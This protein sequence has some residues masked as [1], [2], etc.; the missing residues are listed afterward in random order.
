MA[1]V[2]YFDNYTNYGRD[3]SV[4]SSVIEAFKAAGETGR[5]VQFRIYVAATTKAAALEAITAV[6]LRPKTAH[7]RIGMGNDLD[8]MISSGLLDDGAVY[9]M[10]LNGHFDAPVV[11][12]DA[13]GATV[14]GHLHKE[15]FKP[16]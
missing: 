6:G 5:M 7:L 9:F 16:A 4:P 3:L 13:D 10:M 14:A 11:R 15:G 12:L 8:V 1:K 2:K